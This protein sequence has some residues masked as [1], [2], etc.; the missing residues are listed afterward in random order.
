MDKKMK[1]IALVLLLALIAT[2]IVYLESAKKDGNSQEEGLQVVDE[3]VKKEPAI[4]QTSSKY[5]FKDI[6]LW[7]N[8][9]PLTLP[10]LRGNVVIIDFWTLGCYN[11]INTLPY[12]KSWHEKYAQEGL[13]I[14][15]VH[16]PEFAYERKIENVQAAV[17]QHRIEYPVAIDNQFSTWNTFENRYWPHLFLFDKE[18]NLRFHHIGE[19]AY[20]ETEQWIVKLLNE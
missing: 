13:V 11:C 20:E 5:D 3:S 9:E 18:G 19:G 8:S 10:G 7:I 16:S 6:E 1:S 14:V 2:T 12:V 4:V 17:E 15:G